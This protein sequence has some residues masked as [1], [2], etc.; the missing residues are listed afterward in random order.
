[1]VIKL[2]AGGR[3]LRVASSPDDVP[4]QESMFGVY[5]LLLRVSA[6]SDRPRLM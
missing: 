5:D 6:M 2:C 4:L 3:L 1:M